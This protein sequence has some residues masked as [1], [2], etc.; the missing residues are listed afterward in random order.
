MYNSCIDSLKASSWISPEKQIA[1]TT[2]DIECQE[3]WLLEFTY[4]ESADQNIDY[5][6]DPHDGIPC[7]YIF[8]R[9]Y[10]VSGRVMLKPSEVSASESEEFQWRG[11]GGFPIDQKYA[12]DDVYLRIQDD[13][14]SLFYEYWG[15]DTDGFD[16]Y[17]YEENTWSARYDGSLPISIRLW[18]FTFPE[19]QGYPAGL[20]Y[21]IDGI[22]YEDN[23]MPTIPYQYTHK[24]HHY[25]G[26]PLE[27]S[28]A[29]TCESS[30]FWQ[31]WRDFV[32]P[33]YGNAEYWYDQK[34]VSGACLGATYPWGCTL[35]I[36]SVP[37]EDWNPVDQG[38]GYGGY[39]NAETQGQWTWTLTKVEQ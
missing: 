36:P 34:V 12:S 19:N 31:I 35:G 38:I 37:I 5:R 2:F 14:H 20:H 28:R 6:N 26:G 33:V 22:P 16:D 30:H 24:C 1:T 29:G 15:S 32:D 3:G 18:V 8:E 4:T 10:T 7:A 25:N 27:E 17:D 21:W 11:A 9:R 13:L 23:A 39:F